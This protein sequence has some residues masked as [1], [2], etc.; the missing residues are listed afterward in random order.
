VTERTPVQRVWAALK[1]RGIAWREE[2]RIVHRAGKRWRL[3]VEQ[4]IDSVERWGPDSGPAR[5]ALLDMVRVAWGDSDHAQRVVFVCPCV[6][7]GGFVV[8]MMT[9]VMG[10]RVVRP[11][12]GLVYDDPRGDIELLALVAALEAAPGG[13]S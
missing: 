1:A 9:T 5:G 6:E 10:R 4:W 12:P 8:R 11:L 2:G 13:G 7:V 3:L